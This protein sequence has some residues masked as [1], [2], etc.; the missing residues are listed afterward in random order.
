MQKG[1]DP[2]AFRDFI[3]RGAI[4]P[5]PIHPTQNTLSQFLAKNG[6]PVPPGE[7]E[8]AARG[9][10]TEGEAAPEPEASEG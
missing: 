10:T 7:P 8:G 2:V 1:G 5:G 3:A 6:H 9:G 4:H